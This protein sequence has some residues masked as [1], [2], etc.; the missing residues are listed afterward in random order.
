MLIK[1]HVKRPLFE[2]HYN[3]AAGVYCVPCPVLAFCPQEQQ[4]LQYLK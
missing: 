1:F 4:W 3:L 2:I